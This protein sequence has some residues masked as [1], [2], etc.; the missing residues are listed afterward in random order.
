MRMSGWRS[1]GPRGVVAISEIKSLCQGLKPRPLSRESQ[2]IQRGGDG[3]FIIV[4][5]HRKKAGVVVQT[6]MIDGC[7][8]RSS[9]TLTTASTP[10]TGTRVIKYIQPNERLRRTEKIS[11]GIMGH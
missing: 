7:L 5:V 2:S 4:E 3:V 8:R 6:A 9:M 1:T 11:T 10:R